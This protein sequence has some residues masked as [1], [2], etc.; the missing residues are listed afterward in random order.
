MRLEADLWGACARGELE[1]HYQPLVSLAD[2]RITGVEGLLRWRHP[3]RGMQSPAV[4]IPIAE[5]TG[6][7]VPIGR[8]V[9]ASA[10]EAAAGW[11]AARPDAPLAVHVNLSAAQLADATL[12][13]H[14]E[15]C[16]EEWSVAPEQLVLEITESVVLDDD[17]TSRRRVDALEAVG[18]RLAL[19]DFGTGYS[20]LGYLPRFPLDVLKLDRVFLT[21]P[22]DP[23]RTRTIVQAVI[24]MAHGLG[25]AVVA[26]GVETAEQLALVRRL[27]CD[28][29]QGYL[30]ARPVPVADLHRLLRD[31][32]TWLATFA[33][34]LSR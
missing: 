13:E 34:L 22:G 23:A 24:E 12:A 4:F 15:G 10:C 16:L 30:L 11:N 33:G 7:I 27:G 28:L 8:Y 17:R 21:G 14:L 1:L 26:E 6:A 9:I 32:P 5:A 18:V 29:A 25:L 2:G 31:E 20:S 19:D 3:E